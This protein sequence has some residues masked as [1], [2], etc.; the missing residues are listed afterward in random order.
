MTSVVPG[1]HVFPFYVPEDPNCPYI[2]SE[3]T[4]L[5]QTIRKTKGAGV[6]PHSTSRFSCKS[7]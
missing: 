2:K 4:N 3:K 7:R 5:C 1:D 6:M